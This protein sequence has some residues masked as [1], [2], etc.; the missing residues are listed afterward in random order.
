MHKL[1]GIIGVRKYFLDITKV[2]IHT[3]NTAHHS[4]LSS[5]LVKYYREKV[6][7]VVLTGTYEQECKTYHFAVSTFISFVILGK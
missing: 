2:P 5:V 1:I 7:T 4:L 6:T 3:E